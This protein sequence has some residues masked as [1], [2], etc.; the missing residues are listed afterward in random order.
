MNP[1]DVIEAYVAE[2]MRRLPAKERN[3][4]GLELRDLLA[5]MLA[6]RAQAAGKPADDAMVLAMLKEFGTP[7]DIAERYHVPGAVII[8]ATQTRS[9]AVL[10]IGGVA[11]QWALTLPAVFGGQPVV[12]WWFSWGLGSFWWPG[13]MVMSALVAAG[14]RR[15]GWWQPVWRPRLVDPDRVNRPVMLIGLV[16]FVL[17]VALMVSLPWIAPKLPGALAQVFAFGEGFL[18]RRAWPVLLLWGVSFALEVAAYVQGRRSTAMRRWDVAFSL[19]WIALLVWWMAAG[20]MFQAKATDDG[21]R[22]ALALIMLIIV[23]DL[24]YRLYR[25]RPSMHPPRVAG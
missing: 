3:E 7:T 13:L 9:F 14:V 22:G 20:A 4:I 2:V 5:E 11:L 25:R 16:W 1:N 15:L 8:P 12:A 24:G 17:G 6:E 19:A 18:S 21:A 23:V 10:A